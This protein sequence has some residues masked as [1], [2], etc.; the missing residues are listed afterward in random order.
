MAATEA[1]SARPARAQSG[2]ATR[3]IAS[4]VVSAIGASVRHT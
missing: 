2:W 1:A 3:G 4:S